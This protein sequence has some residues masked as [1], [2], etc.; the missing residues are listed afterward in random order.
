MN[1]KWLVD[2]DEV[3]PDLTEDEV[4]KKTGYVNTYLLS[5][6]SDEYK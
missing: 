4:Q 1:L 5:R 6:L 3:K 2:N